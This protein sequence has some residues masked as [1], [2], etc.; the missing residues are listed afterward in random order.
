MMIS[1]KTMLMRLK[2]LRIRWYSCTGAIISFFILNF[3]Y[4]WNYDVYN[5]KVLAIFGHFI[6]RFK[7]TLEISKKYLTQKGHYGTIQ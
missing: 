3:I 7:Y 5:E 6:L 4:I 1:I 2:V